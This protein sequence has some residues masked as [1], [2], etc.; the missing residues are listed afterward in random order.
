MSNAL[1]RLGQLVATPGALDDLIASEMRGADL[2]RRHVAG[3]FGD[4]DPDDI[5]ANLGDI[6]CGNGRVLSRYTLAGGQRL[7]VIT[8]I[9]D[10]EA[11]DTCILRPDEY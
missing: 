9:V 2:L 1:F 11:C 3:D 5:R 6:A 4:L 7:W 10:G 8:N